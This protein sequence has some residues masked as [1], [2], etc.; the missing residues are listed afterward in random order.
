M[1]AAKPPNDPLLLVL[2]LALAGAAV[3]LAVG[4][5]PREAGGSALGS[6][7]GILEQPIQRA[8]N[9]VITSATNLRDETTAEG[10]AVRQLGSA[11]STGGSTSRKHRSRIQES[12][13][14]SNREREGAELHS[15]R[16]FRDASRSDVERWQID[17]LGTWRIWY[18]GRKLPHE[19]KVP[20]W[21]LAKIA[22]ATEVL[23]RV[24]L[25]GQQDGNGPLPGPYRY[26]SEPSFSDGNAAALLGYR[27]SEWGL[28]SASLKESF[29]RRHPASVTPNSPAQDI[30]TQKRLELDA[31]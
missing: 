5:R 13:F 14:T 16:I 6:L 24:G 30:E 2:G 28:Y 22:W 31:R 12:L 23:H 4:R 10:R 20:E 1:A 27:E 21:A 11:L 17:E 9:E 3:Y 8:A 7:L 25:E 26:L 18:R 15:Q 29:A 19:I